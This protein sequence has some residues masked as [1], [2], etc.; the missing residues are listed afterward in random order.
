MSYISLKKFQ[1]LNDILKQYF[2]PETCSG[3]LLLFSLE[4]HV[5]GQASQHQHFHRSMTAAVP[6][7]A[8]LRGRFIRSTSHPPAHLVLP[9][10]KVQ[11]SRIPTDI[12]I[13]TQGGWILASCCRLLANSRAHVCLL[14]YFSN[15]AHQYSTKFQGLIQKPTSSRKLSPHLHPDSH[16]RRMNRQRAAFPSMFSSARQ[17]LLHAWSPQ[18]G[19]VSADA[20]PG[21]A[22]GRYFANAAWNHLISSGPP[23]HVFYFSSNHH[24]TQHSFNQLTW[25]FFYCFNRLFCPVSSQFINSFMLGAF[26]HVRCTK[27][28][29]EEYT[30]KISVE[31]DGWEWHL[32]LSEH[33]QSCRVLYI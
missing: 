7:W 32:L 10:A 19:L 18:R 6:S 28:A 17:A 4:A 20:A 2:S 1:F 8:L 26:L 31:V 14:C 30:W 9:K 13:E 29:Y 24:N 5:S 27:S 15:Y 25:P 12:E 11:S 21:R 16:H 22:R 33:S 23:V 3:R